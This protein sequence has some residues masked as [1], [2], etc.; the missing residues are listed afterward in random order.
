MHIYIYMYIYIYMN[1]MILYVYTCILL[2]VYIYTSYVSLIETVSPLSAELSPDLEWW[3][4]SLGTDTICCEITSVL[5][6][7]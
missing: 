4:R 7:W 2:C 1:I 6:L 3:G 5:L